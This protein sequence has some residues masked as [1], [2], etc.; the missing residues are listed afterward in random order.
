MSKDDN[1]EEINDSQKIFER[2]EN[3]SKTFEKI[4]AILIGFSVFF[5][6]TAF[7][8]YYSVQYEKAN[9]LP[10][11]TRVR[12]EITPISL[13][14]RDISQEKLNVQRNI[15]EVNSDIQ[16]LQTT[17]NNKMIPDI[18]NVQNTISQISSDINAINQTIEGVV[19]LRQNITDSPE[20]L[21]DF[22]RQMNDKT[23]VSNVCGDRSQTNDTWWANCNVNEKVNE[24]FFGYGQI[25]QQNIVTPIQTLSNESQLGFDF[26]AF[27]QELDEL[28]DWFNQKYEQN[29]LFW[30]TVEG[31]RHLFGD[32]D[33]GTAG[34]WNEYALGIAN[35]RLVLED[36]LTDKES[37]LKALQS[38]LKALEDNLTPRQTEVKK[39]QEQ[40]TQLDGNLTSLSANLDDLLARN[41][42]LTSQLTPLQNIERDLTEKWE[43]I[44]SPFGSFP[45][46]LTELVSLFPVSLAVGFL[47][48][49]LL[50]K[51]MT[52]L[53]RLIHY[54]YQKKSSTSSI[55]ADLKVAYIAPLW[56]DPSNPEQ[57]KLLRFLV[58]SV[59]MVIFVVSLIMIFYLWFFTFNDASSLTTVKEYEKLVY[60][61]LYALSTGFFV[62][63]YFLIKNGLESYFRQIPKNSQSMVNAIIEGGIRKLVKNRKISLEQAYTLIQ[64]LSDYKR[65]RDDGDFL[66]ANLQIDEFIE[67]LS[68]FSELL[69]LED[70]MRVVKEEAH[71]LRIEYPY[72]GK[73]KAETPA[74][75]P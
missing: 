36:N 31:K 15:T 39:L 40:S 25:I 34:L 69:K 48:C 37:N 50:I 66:R 26:Q 14:I 27:Q 16:E 9:L 58:L 70:E 19:I 8:Q 17:I 11:I 56:I 24:Y 3:K 20:N 59:P 46:E 64:K 5:F 65:F 29:P 72:G 43:E 51:D 38:E 6:F 52:R 68:E 41:Q 49:S 12:D 4:F 74:N 60:G 13:E 1:E 33:N 32:L 45:I 22:I 54:S 62:Y 57:S 18:E 44:Q 28:Q 61:G 73:E 23:I 47:V 63:G 10:N 2:Y 7:W 67:Q 75:P 71:R 55:V 35:Q 42:T 53:R 30:V 21:R